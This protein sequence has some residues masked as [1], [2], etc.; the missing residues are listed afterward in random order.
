M[1]MRSLPLWD[2]VGSAE[3]EDIYSSET[4]LAPRRY[5]HQSWFGWGVLHDGV[6]HWFSHRQKAGLCVTHIEALSKEQ[7]E[8]AKRRERG[9]KVKE[10]ILI[11]G[12]QK[13]KWTT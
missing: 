10:F 9:K 11:V 8:A 4:G 12:K 1:L 5:K 7:T 2:H 13:I 3:C 6:I